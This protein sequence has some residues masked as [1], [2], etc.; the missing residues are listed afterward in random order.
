MIEELM[1][2]MIPRVK[3]EK[4]ASAPPENMSIRPKRVPA[5]LSNTAL[6]AR[7]SIPGVGMWIPIR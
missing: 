5:W 1:Y 7:L 4:R 6:S 2:G 3:M